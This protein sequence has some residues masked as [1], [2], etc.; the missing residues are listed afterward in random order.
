MPHLQSTR[1]GRAPTRLSAR[2]SVGTGGGA[3][4]LLTSPASHGGR[5]CCFRCEERGEQEVNGLGFPVIPAG[6]GFDPPPSPGSRRIR[7]DGLQQPAGQT[8]QN[9]P[10]RAPPAG[11]NRGPGPGCGLGARRGACERVGRG[12]K[13]PLGRINSIESR[14][15]FIFSE[16]F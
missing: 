3:A 8:G 15:P 6:R 5:R 2:A 9:Q 12:P 7:S 16:A 1:R 14:F 10:K 13:A 4:A 11:R